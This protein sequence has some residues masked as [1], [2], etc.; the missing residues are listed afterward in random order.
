MNRISK[1]LILLACAG[2][3][4]ALVSCSANSHDQTRFPDADSDGT[5]TL[6]TY[7]VPPGD[8]QALS[9]A[10]NHV[11]GLDNYKHDI[12]R[13]Y[14]SG[15]GQVLVLAPAPLQA[16]IADA[17]N[18]I[19]SRNRYAT[20]AQPLRLNVWLVDV[21]EGTGN[22]D[23]ALKTIQP[24]LQSFEQ[25]SGPAYFALKHYF[26][27]VSD[28]GAET[29]MAPLPYYLL[30]YSISGNKDG[31]TLKFDYRH[32]FTGPGGAEMLSGQVTTRLDQ[33]LVLGLL[34]GPSA[35]EGTESVHRGGGAGQAPGSRY[36]LLVIR[37]VPAAQG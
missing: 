32:H 37:I 11:L 20:G 16:S 14:V 33:T 31:L 9:G 6:R 25:D 26:T 27:E 35:G 28:P 2:L 21:Y 22:P 19:V 23:P 3:A 4:T 24:A 18:Q 36:K 29:T 12:G 15:P 8:A 10:L 34:A 13:T 7:A 30:N 1:P 5:L 17:I